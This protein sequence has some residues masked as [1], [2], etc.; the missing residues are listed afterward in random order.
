[1][2]GKDEIYGMSGGF[3]LLQAL[4]S[5]ISLVRNTMNMGPIISGCEAGY[6]R[7]SRF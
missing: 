2:W 5:E 1:M 3:I 6:F 7:F 4:F